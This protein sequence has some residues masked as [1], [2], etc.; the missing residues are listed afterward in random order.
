VKV[1][2]PSSLKFDGTGLIPVIVQE[3]ASGDILMVGYANEEAL[4]KT[5]ES[6]LATFWSRS[7]NKLWQKG[8]TSGNGLRVVEVRTD[9]DRDALLVVVDPVGPTCHTGARTCFGED[10]PTS[11]GLLGDLARVIEA[12]KSASP[13][14]SYTARLLGR[15]EEAIAKVS[16]EAGEVVRAAKGESRERIAE[17]GADLLYHLMVVLAQRQVPIDSILDVLRRRRKESQ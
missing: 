3:R 13:E 14:I 10:S 8:E 12:R 15:A 1:E 2:I 7:R 6:G 9:C 17:E 16:E 11:A 5:A 4:Q